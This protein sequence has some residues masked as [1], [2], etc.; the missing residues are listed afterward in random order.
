[1]A[2]PYRIKR[3]SV[4]GKRPTLADLEKGE[5]ALNFYD[6][7]LF[8][9]RD[10]GGVGIGTTVALLTPWIEDFGG[11]KITFS[12]N[13]VI[14]DGTNSI[15]IPVGNT[16]QRDNVGSAVT[17]QIRYNTSTS[18]F[19]G[20]GS[21]NS[22]GSLGGVKDVDQ[23]THITAESAAGV[24]ED[25]LTFYTAGT[26]KVVITPDGH[27]GIG[28]TTPNTGAHSSNSKILNVGVVTA[29]TYHGDQIVGTPT[30]GSFRSGAMSSPNVADKTKDQVEELNYILGKLV[31]AAPP[32]I[33]GKAFSFLDSARSSGWSSSSWTQSGYLCAGF[34]PDNHTEG[35]YTPNTTTLL[36]RNVDNK[37]QSTTITQIGPGDSGTVT[38]YVNNVGVGTTTLNITYGLYASKSDNGTYGDLVIS[39]DVDYSTIAGISSFFYEVYDVKI[40]SDSGSIG[41]ACSTGVCKAYIKHGANQ[42]ANAYWYEDPS[43]VSAPVIS[44]GSVTIPASPTLA[45]SSG[46]PHYTQASAN[47]FSYDLTVTNASGDMYYYSDYK[48]VVAENATTGFSKPVANLKYNQFYSGATQ[49]THPPQ[50]NFGV[51][52]GVTTSVSHVVRNIHDTITSSEPFHGWDCYTPYGQHINQHRS[53]TPDINIMG[54]TATTAKM[55]EDNISCSVGTGSSVPVRSK[56]GSGA[57]NPSPTFATWTGGSAGSI[58]TFEGVVRGGVLRHD[59]TNYASGYVP[60]GPDYSSGRSGAQY[61][62]VT[63]ERSNISTFNI[64]FNG[65]I[66]GCW[67]NM[68]N[69][70]SWTTSLSG[71]NGWADMFNEYVG[72]G[73][74]RNADPGCAYGGAMTTA[75][76]SQTKTCTFGTESSSN[77]SDNIILVRFKLASGDYINSMS[78]TST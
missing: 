43:S 14:I 74:P 27:V 3:S 56:A 44:F 54:T 50:R 78:F 26:T 52:S 12:G 46:V 17:G 32:T 77:A 67:V 15:Q 72:S 5:L 62:Q 4:T 42:S 71:T 33:S 55:D 18:S 58:D 70:S 64:T 63:I 30:G 37:F 38:G 13:R 48:L 66:A 31:P 41:Y 57:D 49:G 25:R 22:W 11:G 59:E 16:S 73:V 65:A 34:T 61:F 8:A 75:T 36:D 6:G 69:N 24:D 19:E 35:D 7:H 53:Y 76:G 40:N 68:P 10:T 1:M 45:Y 9:E 20:F 23:D 51:S 39:N 29:N 28:S 47:A 21:G 2:T 60:A